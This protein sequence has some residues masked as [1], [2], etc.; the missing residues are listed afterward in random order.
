MITSLR[1]SS[2]RQQRRVLGADAPENN[3]IAMYE[4][5]SREI[6]GER[7]DAPLILSARS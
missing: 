2:S 5:T 4:W 1:C 3:R 6:V 7:P